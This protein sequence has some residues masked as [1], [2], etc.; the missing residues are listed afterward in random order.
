MSKFQDYIPQSMPVYRG[1]PN[2]TGGASADVHYQNHRLWQSQD[3]GSDVFRYT[4]PHDGTYYTIPTMF[5]K[6]VAGGDPLDSFGLYS[7]DG[8]LAQVFNTLPSSNSYDLDDTPNYEALLIPAQRYTIVYDTDNPGTGTNVQKGV[9][10]YFKFSD[11]TTNWYSEVFYLTASGTISA[12]LPMVMPTKCDGAP[13]WIQL[14]WTND[15][16]VISETFPTEATFAL[17]LQAVLSRPT[18]R[19]V[20]EA[21]DDGEGGEVKLFQRLE[22]RWEFFIVGP[23]YLADMLAATQVFSDVGINF[24][25]DD[26]ITCSDI[27]VETEPLENGLHRI[28]YRFSTTFLTKTGCCG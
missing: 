22:K 4:L 17:N 20:D 26:T 12:I 9:P 5:V 2:Y 10:Y 16:C 11:G 18:Y 24:Q 15:G 7:L 6:R 25:Y 13:E 28:T 1:L 23:E 21:E 19:L 27:E 8:T 3:Q 14:V